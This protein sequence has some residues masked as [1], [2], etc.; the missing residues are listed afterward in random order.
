M[1]IFIRTTAVLFLL[2]IATSAAFS[3]RC[4]QG[5]NEINVY[6]R[7]GQNAVNARFHLYTVSPIAYSEEEGINKVNKVAEFLSTTFFP[8][9]EVYLSRWWSRPKLVRADV[10]DEFLKYYDPKD[11]E[12]PVIDKRDT[13]SAFS[14][15]IA[16]DSF[17]FTTYETNGDPYLLKVW[18]DNYEPVY[19]LATHRGGCSKRFDLLLTNYRRP[20]SKG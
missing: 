5:I 11:F 16:G 2:A 7:N 10:A 8:T 18:A 13:R 20:A 1:K 9:E 15:K 12:E 3:Q 4:G 17:S 19:V 6:V 14:G